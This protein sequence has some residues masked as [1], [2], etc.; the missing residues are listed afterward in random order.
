[1][2]QEN[3]YS[4]ANIEN[5]GVYKAARAR[6]RRAIMNRDYPAIEW[7]LLAMITASPARIQERLEL[8]NHSLTHNRREKAAQYLADVPITTDQRDPML[9]AQVYHDLMRLNLVLKNNQA[10]AEIAQLLMPDFGE[11]AETAIM[12]LRAFARA[13]DEPGFLTSLDQVLGLC[14][15]DQ[16]LLAEIFTLLNNRS[17]SYKVVEH[18]QALGL[19]NSVD[20]EISFQYGRALA[21]I[22]PTGEAT[23]AAVERAHEIGGRPQKSARLLSKL[24]LSVNRNQD[25]LQVLGAHSGGAQPESVRAQYADALMAN[26]HFQEAAAGYDDLLQKHPHHGGWRRACISALLLA[27][28]EA[29]AKAMYREGL[30]G[31][32]LSKY[33]N[34]SAALDAIDFN[35]DASKIPAYRFDWAYEKLRQMG[36][37]P[38]DRAA[39]ELECKWVNLADHLTLDWLE[40][41]AQDSDE[42]LPFIHGAAEARAMIQEKTANG[43]G[44]FIATAHIG[45]LFAGPF[46]LA[47]SGLNYRW[48]ASTPLVSNIPGAEFL[49]STYS[50]NKMALARKIFGAIK[51][52]A[53]V[54]I[55]I[56]GNSGVQTSTVPFLGDTIRLSD[57]IPRMTFQ[58]G[59]SSFFPKVIWVAGVVKIELVPLVMPAPNDTLEAYIE[60]WFEDFLTQLGNV[61]R[62][63]PENLRMT[64]GFWDEVTL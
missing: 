29:G 34:F 38:A 60:I 39:W 58:T 4:A 28:D 40:A 11:D 42:I 16:A 20:F 63:A 64:G 31:R 9:P 19:E 32:N 57:F 25:S 52:G 5:S 35:M 48:V 2:D 12:A 50:K 37:A 22:D 43:V 56:D 59:A 33:A 13:N 6:L 10:A 23:I 17:L 7:E 30:E 53:V 54:S 21:E 45:G 51:A 24:Y 27:G 62:E 55:A 18:I 15:H 41:R 36:C 61:F 44:A 1:M 8:V 3:A 49:L 47:K 46:A 14:R 26:G